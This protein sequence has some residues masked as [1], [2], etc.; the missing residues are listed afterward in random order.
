MIWAASSFVV[1]KKKNI[2]CA[3]S[4]WDADSVHLHSV[5]RL[6][7]RRRSGDLREPKAYDYYGI[8][9]TTKKALQKQ[10]SCYLFRKTRFKSL[11]PILCVR[12][13]HVNGL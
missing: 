7:P 3:V 6:Y 8:G 1:K 13:S 4:Q 11:D 9:V 10:V 2:K 5:R 12:G